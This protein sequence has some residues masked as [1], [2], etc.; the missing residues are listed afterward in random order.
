MCIAEIRAERIAARLEKELHSNKIVIIAE[1]MH[2]GVKVNQ[3][4]ET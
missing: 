4:R 3:G 1:T 2:V